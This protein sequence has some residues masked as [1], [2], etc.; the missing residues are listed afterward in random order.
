M[1]G[2]DEAVIVAL[3]AL[4]W[5]VAE[6]DLLP[7]FLTATGADA[8]ALRS[9]AGEPAF[10]GAVL[11]FILQDDAVV[12]RFCTAAGLAY[13]VPLEARQALPGGGAVHWT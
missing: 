1:I 13:A 6:E 10:L 9:Q 5:L 7:V 4:G 12:V 11:D 2:Q 3:K 8:Q